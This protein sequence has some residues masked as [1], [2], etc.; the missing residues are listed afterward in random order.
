MSAEPM[1]E[2][3]SN[4]GD[5]DRGHHQMRTLHAV[6]SRPDLLALSE[7]TDGDGGVVNVSGDRRAHLSSAWGKLARFRDLIELGVDDP[8]VIDPL[9]DAYGR[10]FSHRDLKEIAALRRECAYR[11]KRTS[12]R[13]LPGHG[14]HVVA[15]SPKPQI[16]RPAE[17]ETSCLVPE[18]ETPREKNRRGLCRR[19]YD[20]AYRRSC[21]DLRGVTT[22]KLIRM[23]RGGEK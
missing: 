2:E 13:P 6:S 8:T 19:H 22:E 17:T 14:L 4:A 10:P 18:C 3:D 20:R 9:R 15:R 5:S 16:E 11:D 12:D 1:Y 23:A 7:S 21:C